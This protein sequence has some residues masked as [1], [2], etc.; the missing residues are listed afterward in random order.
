MIQTP[1][2]GYG[3]Y[4]NPWGCPCIVLIAERSISNNL[5]HCICQQLFICTNIS[6]VR[7]FLRNFR[8]IIIKAIIQS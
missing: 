8:I 5:P 4:N 2:T 6:K 7:F 3:I 1:F